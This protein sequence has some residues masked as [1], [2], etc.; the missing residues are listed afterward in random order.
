MSSL[1]RSDGQTAVSAT[2]HDFVAANRAHFDGRAHIIEETHAET[3]ELARREI[4]AMLKAWPKLF[5]EDT[6]E[7]MDYACGTGALLL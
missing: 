6:T 2:P 5:E 1:V 4:R 3:P 7:A